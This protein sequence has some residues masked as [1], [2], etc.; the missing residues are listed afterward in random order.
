M[1]FYAAALQTL[2][3]DWDTLPH[4]PSFADGAVGVR[5]C[6]L[7]PRRQQE[8]YKNPQAPP[9]LVSSH[10]VAHQPEERGE[11]IGLQRVLGL[12]SYKTAWTW[13]HK[14]RRAMVRPGRDRLRGRV[15]VDETYLG[16]WRIRAGPPNRRESA[17]LAVAAEEVAPASDEFG[18]ARFRTPLGTA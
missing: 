15:E 13:L 3:Y 4:R 16:P 11:C 6:G 9:E 10:V 5:S 17:D 8:R 7:K 18:C 2:N 12:G 14:L 1:L